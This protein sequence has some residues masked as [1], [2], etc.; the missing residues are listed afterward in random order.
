ME[1]SICINASNLHVGG[2]VQ[3]AASFIYELSCMESKAKA[4][5]VF[6]SNEVFRNASQLGADFG[7]FARFEV[8]DVHGIGAMKWEVAKRF[9]SYPLIFTVFGPFYLPYIPLR[10]VVGF[11]QPWIIYPDNEL[12]KRASLIARLKMRMRFLLQSCFFWMADDL[13]VE[14]D[15]VKDGLI[16]RFKYPAQNIHIVR[17]CISPVFFDESK[18]RPVVGYE[19]SDRF[20]I[21][22]V[23]RD[24]PH[25]NTNALAEMRVALREKHNIDVDVLVTLRDDE[26]SLKGDEFR[27]EVINI[28]PLTIAQ[29]PSFYNLLDA[30]VFPS[31]LEC[32]S[33]TP[34]EAM[35]MRK[36]LFASDKQFVRD[37]CGDFAQYFDPLDPESAADSVAKY[38]LHDRELSA[39]RLEEAR[40]HAV[41]FSSSRSRA[42][43]YLKVLDAASLGRS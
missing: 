12:S 42:L 6:V 40:A 43:S 35:V 32:F 33:A 9:K 20:T 29:C 3:V 36:P 13:V 25:K 5:D 15:H 16:G 23:G 4:F 26:W 38:I 30:V 10:H 21:G 31:F 28:G 22:F 14:L 11:A 8:L 37:V 41:N 24:Y 7:R 18:W 27:R 39:V 19:R 1:K 17:N 2:G 34:L